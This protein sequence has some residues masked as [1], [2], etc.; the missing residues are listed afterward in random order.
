MQRYFFSA[1]ILAL[2]LFAGPLACSNDDMYVEGNHDADGDAGMTDNDS[3]TEID[4]GETDAAIDVKSM[5]EDVHHDDS[6][7]RPVVEINVGP[8]SRTNETSAEFA[9]HC[10]HPPSCD[11]ECT[12]NGA[13]PEYCESPTSYAD[14]DDGTHQFAVVATVDDGTESDRATWN[15]TIDTTP[16]E[17]SILSAPPAA[18]SETSATFEFECTD[19]PDCTFQCALD[20]GD[21]GGDMQWQECLSGH[22]ID[23]LPLGDHELNIRATDEL[24]N[25]DTKTVGWTVV[26]FDGW[27]IST[28][29][30][31]SCGVRDDGTLW[32]WGQGSR[33]RL[34]LVDT[35]GREKPAQVGDAQS[36]SQV[37]AGG[38]FTCA[39][40]DDKTLWCWGRNKGGQL[41]VGDTEDRYEPT[42]AGSD[43]NWSSVTTG[44][45]HACGLRDDGTLWCWGTGRRGRLGLGDDDDRD[46]PEQVGGD[47]NWNSVV[48]GMRHSC[49]IR[50]DHTLWCWGRGTGNDV[51]GQIGGDSDWL[52]AS[53][54][55]GY[56]CAVRTDHTLWC[57]GLG[58]DGQL[59]IGDTDDRD[60]P[61]QLGSD[62]HWSSVNAG[63]FHACGVRD[64]DTL[65]CWGLGDDGRL[66]NG[67]TD[68]RLTPSQVDSSANWA[69]VAAGGAHSCG[70]S[71][72]NILSCWGSGDDGRLGSGDTDRRLTP[73]EVE[74]DAP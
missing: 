13:S 18:T 41:G 45:T 37:S 42:Q 59:G 58:E 25:Q 12:I 62:T 15:W 63:R 49:A 46:S 17:I 50:D 16:P 47:S 44:G 6:T 66:G 72:D 9:F 32:C 4:A 56:T 68:H 61:S 33:G 5:E 60:T 34:G 57:W 8:E 65:W 51:P 27:D 19:K 7:E 11:F 54:N 29:I 71:T 14:L 2:A 24:G 64:D 73:H 22:T 48:A 36:W 26:A 31:H 1:L 40:R 53:A 23:D 67:D 21:T 28:G 52:S 3:G 10:D 39:V 55:R 20:A 43:S 74:I 38:S 70:V 69:R 35:D 30:D